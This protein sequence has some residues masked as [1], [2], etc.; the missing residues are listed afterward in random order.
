MQIQFKHFFFYA[1]LIAAFT[2][3]A[4][5]DDGNP[6]RQG[7]ELPS[8]VSS[9]SESKKEQS[10][11]S[12]KKEQSSS[13]YYKENWDYLNPEIDYGEIE[14]ARDG[15][16]YKTVK[17]DDQTWMAENLNYDADNSFCYNDSMKYC[18]KY[19]RLYPWGVAMDSAG[20]FS[21]SGKGCGAGKFCTPIFPVRGVCPKGWHL[22]SRV[23]WEHLFKAYTGFPEEITG[24]ILLSTLRAKKGWELNG[25]DTYGFSAL[26]AGWGEANFWGS[27]YFW[28][29]GEETHFWSSNELAG[30]GEFSGKW[31]AYSV[32]SNEGTYYLDYNL[33]KEQ[34][35]SVRCLKDE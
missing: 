31:L 33:G 19:G 27:F 14:D 18:N 13:S 22:P 9:S 29:G 11:S 30:D 12:Y 8:S 6:T 34:G 4:C 26:P 21:S 10:S 5:S 32:Q 24:S 1:A 20:K 35:F 7:D 28:C 2:V 15:Q 17:I 23:E 3:V 25:E 16:I